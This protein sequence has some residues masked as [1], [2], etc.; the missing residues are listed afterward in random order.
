MGAAVWQWL[1]GRLAA[2]GRLGGLR[3][4]RGRLGTRLLGHRAESEAAA[5]L[6]RQRYRILAR[7]LRIRF[8]EVDLLAQAPDGRTLVVVEVKALQ[9]R[10]GEGGSTGGAGRPE[11]PEMHVDARKQ[12]KVASVAVRILQRYRLTGRPIRFDVIAIEASQ[13]A[14]STIRHHPGA[15]ESPW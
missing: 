4:A 9:G 13:Q 15:F 3:G 5:Y 10:S 14:P 8:G 12:R 6:K 7:N 1:T 11:S 2:L